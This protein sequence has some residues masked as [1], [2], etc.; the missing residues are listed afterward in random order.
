MT[1]AERPR[2]ILLVNGPNLNLLGVREPEIYG[3]HT[4]EDVVVM[5]TEAAARHGL[6]V[7]HV[8]SNHEGELIDAIQAA[9]LDLHGR[10]HQPR[11][12]HGHLGGA[13]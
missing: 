4:L 2:Q 11:R 13:A 10:G 6:G 8:Q 3:H 1:T 9:R 12:L 5:T 7:R